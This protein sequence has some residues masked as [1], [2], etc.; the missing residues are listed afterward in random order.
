MQ[1]FYQ[2]EPAGKTP[3]ELERFLD[4]QIA[5]ARA[6]R[7]GPPARRAAA[8]AGF[9]LLILA[10]AGFALMILRQELPARHHARGGE[11]EVE[12]FSPQR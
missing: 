3:E 12:K 10:G 11:S 9:L 1:D 7:T 6:R 8:L 4:L 2:I 5:S